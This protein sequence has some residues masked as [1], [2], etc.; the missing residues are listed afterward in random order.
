MS[1]VVAI[2]GRPNVGKS[3]LFNRLIGH[4]QALV[5]DR[6]GVTRDRN[7]G[8]S[9]ALGREVVIVDTGGFEPEPE[10]DLFVV[11][12]AQAEAAIDQA[13]I[14]LFVV[15]RQAGLTPADKLAADILRKRAGQR[16][17]PGGQ[18]RDRIL[19]VVNKC[20]SP[21]HDDDAAEFWS[22]GMD[23]LLPISAEHGRG[24]W[25]L[26]QAVEAMLPPL[27]IEDPTR[28]KTARPKHAAS[29]DAAPKIAAPAGPQDQDLDPDED[30]GWTDAQ[31]P[32]ADD[33]WEAEEDDDGSL[34]D[35]SLPD[36]DPLEPEEE[37]EPGEIRIA[38]LGR[39]NIGKSTLINR[40]L[41]EE[42]HVVHDA[43]GTT[44][45]AVD[46]VLEVEG[47]RYRLVDTAGVRRRT[48]IDDRVESW[49]SLAAIRTIERCHVVLLVIDG[50]LGATNQ[51]TRLA[52]LV[53]D[54]GRACIV[55]VNR[56][57]KVR[58]SPDRNVGVVDDEL[59]RYLPQLSWAPRLYISALTGKG[60]HRILPLVEQVY[61]E[62]DKRI[63][64][65]R[66]NRFL[67][68]AVAA[69]SVPQLHHHPV[70]LNYMTQ[71][72]V[73]PPTFLI[74]A[75]TPDGVKAPYKRYLLNKLREVFGFQG[76]PIRLQLRQK[77]RPG[78]EKEG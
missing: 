73:R 57:D 65:A 50:E 24:V 37:G 76:T 41:G 4:R 54:R 17:G 32:G 8:V 30:L 15:D 63:S 26:W 62:F 34:E 21:K 68:D 33:D 5:D 28:R 56:W 45:D 47:R 20:D 67:E 49:A 22:L 75:N 23:N 52:A 55:L 58:E 46:S 3:T 6:P 42:R 1:P 72:R 29:K 64:T 71:A 2:V 19:L 18:V 78:E 38:V 40:L 70:K 25:E 44:M 10:D 36:A 27:P 61:V 11:V 77:R 51:D 14:I 13:D 7:Y 35:G 48:K 16:M 60:C 66:A 53:E 59:D 9:E 43:P 74:W 69:Y 39:P 31:E 12:R